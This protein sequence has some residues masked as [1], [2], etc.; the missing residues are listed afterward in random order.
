M[1]SPISTDTKKTPKKAPK[2]ARKSNLSIFQISQAAFKSINE[3]TAEIITA[4]RMQLGV[5]L[6]KGVRTNNVMST[7]M[8]ITMLDMAVNTPAL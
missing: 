2:Q 6:N 7:T 5:Y 1:R 4:E 8:D 3:S